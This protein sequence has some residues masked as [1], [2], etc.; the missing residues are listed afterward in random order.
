MKSK[1]LI[2]LI[3]LTVMVLFGLWLPAGAAPSAQVQYATP[4]PGADGRIIYVVQPGDTCIRVALLNGLSVEQL[5]ALNSKLDANCTLITGQ[6]LLIGLSGAAAATPTSGPSPTP[7]P[8][9]FTPTPFTGTTEICVLLFDDQNGDAL[10]QETE[11]AIAGGA[12]SVTEIN[13]KYSASQ[14]TSIN[15]DPT[16]YQGVCFKDVPEGSYNIS[17]AIPD[18]YNPT[19]DLAYKLDVKAGDRA[20][21]PFGAQSTQTTI[22]QP[23]DNGGNSGSSTS[24]LLGIVG[25]L[26]LLGGVGLGWYT[27]WAGRPESKLSGGSKLLKKRK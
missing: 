25:G 26:L 5:R 1:R 14:T 16:V 17:V 13:G 10:R 21:V 4:T 2:V 18:G 19:T 7:A 3:L 27:W 20:F 11:P 15:P 24:I 6:E 8:P 12:V 23:Q 9:T 22:T